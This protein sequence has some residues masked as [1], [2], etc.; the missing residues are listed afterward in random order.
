MTVIGD[1]KEVK[2]R[3]DL[4]LDPG[5]VVTALIRLTV[6]GPVTTAPDIKNLKNPNTQNPA[7]EGHDHD[8]GHVTAAD[9]LEATAGLVDQGQ[10]HG[11]YAVLGQGQGRKTDDELGHHLIADRVEMMILKVALNRTPVHKL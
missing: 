7:E 3:K 8:H 6:V 4:G 5:A 11:N 2:R 1:Q 10:G 9:G